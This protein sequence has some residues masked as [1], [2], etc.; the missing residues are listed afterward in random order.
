MQSVVSI[1]A[2]VLSLKRVLQR[3]T[4]ELPVL[5]KIPSSVRRAPLPANQVRGAER[6]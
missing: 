3:S 2:S 1:Q 5:I 6:E 4:M